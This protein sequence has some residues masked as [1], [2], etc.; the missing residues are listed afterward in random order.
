MKI[1]DFVLLAIMLVGIILGY[2]KGFFGSITKP[3]KLIASFSITVVVA[4]PLIN[5]WTRPLFV[6]KIR[7]WIYDSLIQSMPEV[8]GETVDSIPT[9]LKVF[10]NL[11]NVDLSGIDPS[12]GTE[13]IINEIA[14]KMALPI[15]NLIAVVVTYLV[16]FVIILLILKILIA[17]LDVIFT[18]GL[19][20]KVNKFL[21]MVLGMVV[22]T[23]VCCILASIVGKIS[24]EAV[25]GPVCQFFMNF[26]PFSLLLQI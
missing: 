21:G 4:A 22:T 9:V 8:S 5:A 10:A 17:L 3:I 2:K 20:G 1:F 26:N 23:V 13:F 12:A 18:K 19:L 11:F 14:E 15:G 16:L 24:Y 7:A 6:E 25:A